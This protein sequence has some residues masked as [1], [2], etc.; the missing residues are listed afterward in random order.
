MCNHVTYGRI[1]LF[2]R[3][4]SIKS[5]QFYRLVF[6]IDRASCVKNWSKKKRKKESI[7][8]D[9]LLGSRS[10]IITF[11]CNLELQLQQKTCC[12]QVHEI[13]SR[14]NNETWD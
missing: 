13:I 7:L 8:T 12:K 10:Y 14:F 3:A 6:Q 5:L 4:R 11:S 9:L 1:G 2:L